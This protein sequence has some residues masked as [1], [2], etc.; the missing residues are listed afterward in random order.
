MRNN[1]RLTLGISLL[2]G[3]VPQ[4]LVTY[5]STRFE[6][7]QSTSLAVG[8][9]LLMSVVLGLAIQI[10]PQA[11]L[12]R[13]TVAQ[14]QDREPKFAECAAAALNVALPLIGLGFLIALATTVGFLLLIVPGILLYVI[15]SVAAPA[16][17]E[18]RQG[19][20]AAL[21]RSSELTHG[22]RWKVFGV[23]MVLIAS[24]ILPSGAVE[25]T[26]GSDDAAA[27][28]ADPLYLGATIVTTT[29]SILFSATVQSAMY[30]VLRDLKDGPATSKLEEVFA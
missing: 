24:S 8:A 19:I 16:L 3:T 1:P 7:A 9:V 23:S 18:E 12:T 4:M 27:D 28:Y 21:G 20:F 30:V 26:F 25:A 22:S 11:I 6:A 5:A 17:V 13:V 15:W 10:I 29:L 14:S 2:L